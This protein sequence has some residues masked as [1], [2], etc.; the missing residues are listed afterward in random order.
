MFNIILANDILDISKNITKKD[1]QKNIV[2]IDDKDNLLD[3]E[4]ILKEQKLNHIEK[5]NLGYKYNNFWCKLSVKNFSTKELSKI[6]VNSRAGMDYIDVK[7]YKKDSVELYNLG[8]MVSPDNRSYHSNYSNFELFLKSDEKATL[9]IRYN[10]VGPLEIS[11]NVYDYKNFIKRQNIDNLFVLVFL[12]F[13]LALFI[14]K[15]FIYFHIKDKEYFVYAMMMGTVFVSQISLNGILHLYFYDY[16]HTLTITLINWIFVH[17][18]L[19]LMWIFTYYF[20]NINKNSKH[21]YPL[22]IVIS[23]NILVVFSY[24]LAYYDIKVLEITKIVSTIAFFESIALLLFSIIM[25][26]NKKSGAF[27]FSLGHVFYIVSVI[28]YIMLLKGNIPLNIFT[29][30]SVDIGLLLV[31]LLMSLALSRKFKMIKIENEKQREQLEQ[32][33]QYTMIGATIGYMTH[34]WKQP[35]SILSIQNNNLLLQAE[36]EPDKKIHN[37]KKDFLEVENTIMS[38]NK[39][40]TSIKRLYSTS[41]N[42]NESFYLNDVL[43]KLIKEFFELANEKKINLSIELNENIKVN[44]NENLLYNVLINILQNC[45]EQFSKESQNR[46]IKITTKINKNKNLN[47]YIEDNAGGVHVTPINKIFEPNFTTKEFGTGIG[48]SFSKNIIESKFKGYIKI[49]NKNDGVVFDIKL[50]HIQKE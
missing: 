5:S 45:I 39:T 4:D 49:K 6:F 40:L 37:L 22:I 50:N 25:I 12:G 44:G 36:L 34:Q 35:L 17:M 41:N 29:K 43:N 48:L 1:V 18:F 47:I 8:D 27:F 23:Y 32:N 31:S 33:K 13:I 46:F 7:V 19:V 38:I 9:V 14:Y 15:S 10:S 42:D 30:H 24:S 28:I 2:C 16:I 26:Y 11:W 3:F 20:F 21:Y